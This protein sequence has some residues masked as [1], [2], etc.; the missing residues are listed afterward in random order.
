V[1]GRGLG[2]HV[3]L[4]RLLH[5]ALCDATQLVFMINVSKGDQQALT[6]RVLGLGSYLLVCTC[7]SSLFHSNLSSVALTG[8]K[9]G[10]F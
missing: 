9:N 1:L 5:L 2:M 8:K 3:V 4:G 10:V 7:S 6:E